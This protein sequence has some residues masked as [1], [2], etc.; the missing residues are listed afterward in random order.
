ML[1]RALLLLL[2]RTLAWAHVGSPDVYLD[3]QAGPYKIFVTVRPPAVIPGVAELEVRASNPDVRQIWAVPIPLNQLAARFAPVPDL[4]KVSAQ[5]RQFFTGSLWMMATGSW[6]IRLQVKGSRGGGTVAVPVP[7]VALTTKPMSAGLAWPLGFLMLLLVAGLVLLVG[8]SVREAKLLPGTVPD[9]EAKRRARR[10]MA[11][12]FAIVAGLI[13]VGRWWWSSAEAGYRLKVYRPLQ[14]VATLSPAGILQLRLNNPEW[15]NGPERNAGQNG[16]ALFTRAMD[17]FIPDHEHL[18]HLYAIREPG[19]DVIYHLHPEL[20]ETAQFQLR[21][22]QMPPGS[23]RLYGDVVHANGF[24][25]TMVAEVQV[26]AGLPGRPLEGDDAAGTAA[27]WSDT[28]SSTRFTLPDRYVMQWV[29]PEGA[30]HAKVGMPFRFRLVDESGR[31]ASGMELYMGMPGHAAFVKTDGTTFAHV[32]P[33][34]SVAMASYMMAQ[35]QLATTRL[36]NGAMSM[37]GMDMGESAVPNEVTFP[38]GFPSP[39][40]YRIFVQMKRAGRV[41]TGVFDADVR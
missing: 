27:A 2:L 17:D 36:S 31:P 23:Y 7:S 15:M 29:R 14:M 41:E 10:A 40:K 24:P 5:D 6:Q 8:A 11:M 32:H 30:L 34:G 4:L 1:Q 3:A 35:S 39:G 12:A 13:G 26:P 16:P 37:P 28:S 19:L 21:L 18:M 38:Y 33:N 22:P 20:I 25:E 9:A